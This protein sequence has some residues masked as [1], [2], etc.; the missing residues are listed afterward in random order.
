MH[1]E[2]HRSAAA[3]IRALD[4]RLL[5]FRSK[6]GESA[7]ALASEL[8]AAHRYHDAADV[9]ELAISE[10]GNSDTHLTLMLAK[11]WLMAGEL[12][13]SQALL[14]QTA[15]TQPNH[16]DVFRWLGALL[17]KRGD[18]ER[19]LKVLDRAVFLDK[20]DPDIQALHARAKR[21]LTLADSVVPVQPQEDNSAVAAPV[22]LVS[23]EV[24]VVEPLDESLLEPIDDTDGDAEFEP[25]AETLFYGSQVEAQLKAS[26]A[27][28]WDE[29]LV[30]GVR[31]DDVSEPKRAPQAFR[32][33]GTGTIRGMPG[34]SESGRPIAI[35]DSNVSP[36]AAPPLA[37][38][39]EA[40]PRDATDTGSL[41]GQLVREVLDSQRP[42]PLHKRPSTRPNISLKE[43]ASPSEPVSSEEQL[44]HAQT[45]LFEQ[46]VSGPLELHPPSSQFELTPAEVD[47]F[48]STAMLDKETTE[49]L[50]SRTLGDG[51]RTLRENEPP[52]AAKDH[53][54]H[55]A[56]WPDPGSMQSNA[57]PFVA[58]Q[59]ETA[60]RSLHASLADS[61]KRSQAKRSMQKRR[62]TSNK[63]QGTKSTLGWWLGFFAL[64]AIGFGGYVG[65]SYWQRQKQQQ[66][67]LIV[68]RVRVLALRGDA[69]SLRHAED[70][71]H[72]ALALSPDRAS[73]GNLLLFV[74]MQRA[75]EEGFYDTNALRLS[76]QTLSRRTANTSYR[77]ASFAVLH[78]LASDQTD[79]TQYLHKILG[80][81]KTDPA[82]A[83]VV[84]RLKQRFG[85]SD[86]EQFLR[87]AAEGAPSFSAAELAFVP[88]FLDRGAIS[89]AEQIP[90][91]VLQAYPGHLRALLWS[92]L[93]RVN[94]VKP[95]EMLK[96]LEDQQRNKSAFAPTDRF[97]TELIQLR[98]HAL[99]DDRSG[100]LD[101]MN[102]ASDIVLHDP[103]LSG[104]LA[105]WAQRLGALTEAERT[106]TQAL[107]VTPGNP[108]LKRMLVELRVQQGKPIEGLIAAS[109]VSLDDL[110]GVR[111]RVHAALLS[112]A[113]EELERAHNVLESYVTSEAMARIEINALKIRVALALNQPAE[114]LLEE[115][116]RLEG[117]SSNSREVAVSLIETGLALRDMEAAKRGEIILKKVAPDNAQTYFLKA[118]VLQASGQSRDAEQALRDALK[119]LPGYHPARKELIELLMESGRWA[120][121]ESWLNELPKGT[122]SEANLDDTLTRVRIAAGLKKFK[123]AD[124]LLDALTP[125][126]RNTGRARLLVAH[127]ALAQGKLPEGLEAISG[128]AEQPEA[129]APLLATYG[130]LLLASGWMGRASAAYR[131]A[132][133]KQA[134]LPEALLGQAEVE[135]RASRAS[136]A[137]GLLEQAQTALQ[138]QLR[139][140]AMVAKLWL[141][142]G[143]AYLM[144][145][146]PKRDDAISAFR[147]ATDMSDA[148]PEGYF[149]LGE[150]LSAQSVAD[151][152]VAYRRYL[153]LDPKG[154][155]AERATAALGNAP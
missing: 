61:E 1:D 134:D 151:A 94:N 9:L 97:L 150:A 88:L 34:V 75:L 12:D 83:Y 82:L 99:L 92:M 154:S 115:A 22:S 77:D 29:E 16:K 59:V 7:S 103:V 153:E 53:A 106:I 71:L 8:L 58:S 40:P 112:G 46:S 74:Q 27:G 55:L 149:W 24:S 136:I 146:P 132:L 70:E 100:A 109:G 125:E 56:A 2:Q 116:K 44:S 69:V 104:L 25:E 121:A 110:E 17:L 43:H 143:R 119:L 76:V 84:G 31:E 101:A 10:S 155:Y 140:A 139:P 35:T 130:D 148:V 14:V 54:Q 30:T 96:D 133:G 105:K 11:A 98:M 113:P 108:T 114:P 52:P 48:E 47:T 41:L 65:W 32:P 135:L 89:I 62:R 90:A 87:Q 26:S 23:E 142:K 117:Q 122:T 38:S 63:R 50:R 138:V 129:S 39:R 86:A 42:E 131:G 15:R 128:L 126:E 51:V 147:K 20:H 72:K 144:Q 141:L 68:A 37:S 66:A 118:R 79:A 67:D 57:L 145:V 152:G 13:K 36:E 80:F 5:R 124:Q 107:V 64:I 18:P 137:L 3:P 123:E 4:A 95:R 78:A 91:R 102:R 85:E 60:R 19:A 21:L 45:G 81:T 127:I 73:S 33:V 6:R 28:E 49:A 120:E 111:L 93:I